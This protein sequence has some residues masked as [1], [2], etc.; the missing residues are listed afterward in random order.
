MGNLASVSKAVE[1][2]CGM[3]C[4]TESSPERLADAAGLILPGVGAFGQAVRNLRKTGMFEAIRDWARTG[5]PF[6]GICLGYQLMF[7][8]SEESP[9]VKGLGLVKGKVIRFRTKG[10]KVPH[11]GWNTVEGKVPLLKGVKDRS[12]FY[13]VHS[14]YPVPVDPSVRI[15]KT[16]YEGETFASGISRGTLAGFQFHPEKSQDNGLKILSNFGR[17]CVRS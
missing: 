7:D 10:I 11:I 5:R 9:G 17:L 16:E 13:F 8:S 15:L 4:R 2:A 1:R 12:W 6:L 14:F 3:D